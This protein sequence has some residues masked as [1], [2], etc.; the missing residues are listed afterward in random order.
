MHTIMIETQAIYES[1]MMAVVLY[2]LARLKRVDCDAF[3]ACYDFSAA[4]IHL[5]QIILSR[6]IAT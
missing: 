4:H 6:L 5:N 1:S 3:A 2:R